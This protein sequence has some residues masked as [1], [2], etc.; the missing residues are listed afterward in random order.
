MQSSPIERLLATARALPGDKEELAPLAITPPSTS[1][2]TTTDPGRLADLER[3]VGAL[4]TELADRLE[5]ALTEALDRAVRAWDQADDLTVLDEVLVLR[6]KDL[7]ARWHVAA[8]AGDVTSARALEACLAI[9]AATDLV[10]LLEQRLATFIR[11]H[12]QQHEE[13][14]PSG[15]PFL[16][17][18]AALR[19][20]A[21]R[22]S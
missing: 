22:W 14:L 17:I 12:L 13:L 18:A 5:P 11:L 6:A 7:S 4:L 20:L 8:A 10:R 3:R 16:D 21:R 9:E 15:R 19:E 1:A 2:A